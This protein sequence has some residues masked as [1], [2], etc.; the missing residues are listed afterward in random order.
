M[1][2]EFLYNFLGGD[3]DN[4][5]EFIKE[6]GGIDTEE[7]YPYQGI[8]P[9]M[10]SKCRFSK[11]NVGARVFGYKQIPSG[12]ELALEAAVATVGPI[13]IAIDASQLSAYYSGGVYKFLADNVYLTSLKMNS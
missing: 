11:K 4:A 9:S 3:E 7:S 2:W 8:D 10:G 1:L 13:S 6:Q 5:F 12:D